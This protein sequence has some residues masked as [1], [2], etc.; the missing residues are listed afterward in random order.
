MSLPGRGFVPTGP[1]TMW[2]SPAAA[3]VHLVAPGYRK[4]WTWTSYDKTKHHV[5]DK[6][7]CGTVMVRVN[8]PDGRLECIGEFDQP[9]TPR[10][11]MFC[12]ACIGRLVQMRGVTTE[13]VDVLRKAAP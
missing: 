6:S 7:I 9:I 1:V 10:G 5:N 11:R 13:V 3:I 12:H 2:T 4:Q 8:G